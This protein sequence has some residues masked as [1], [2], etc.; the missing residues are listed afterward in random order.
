[1]VHHTRIFFDLRVI[2]PSWGCFSRSSLLLNHYSSVTFGTRNSLTRLLLRIQT[3]G[4][5]HLWAHLLKVFKNGFNFTSEVDTRS[6]PEGSGRI[7]FYKI[8][9]IS[10][11]LRSSLNFIIPH[12]IFS[13]KSFQSHY[14][15]YEGR[16]NKLN[17]FE[18]RQETVR[19]TYMSPYDDSA[20]LISCICDW[21]RDLLRLIFG[22]V[23]KNVILIFWRHTSCLLSWRSL[24]PKSKV[25][26]EETI[27][28]WSVS[29]YRSVDRAAQDRTSARH[30]SVNNRRIC[31]LRGRAGKTQMKRET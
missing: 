18:L 9:Q 29:K 8:Y 19:A 24:A 16:E 5:S 25:I 12:I 26:V 4:L 11:P 1:M 31:H 3:F 14:A 20:L 15:G 10:C 7:S 28:E 2:A 13:L 27:G 23:C 30:V 21:S 17:R 22:S 6:G